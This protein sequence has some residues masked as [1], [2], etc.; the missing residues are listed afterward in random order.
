MLKLRVRRFNRKHFDCQ[1]KLKKSL[2][3]QKKQIRKN[4]NGSGSAP[5]PPVT[6]QVCAQPNFIFFLV[7]F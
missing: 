1:K 2:E 5:D 4:K 7:T 6:S 3:C